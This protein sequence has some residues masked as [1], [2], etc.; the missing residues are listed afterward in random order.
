MESDNGV[1]RIVTNYPE[2][3]VERP[4]IYLVKRSSGYAMIDCG[5]YEREKDFSHL[6]NELNRLGIDTSLIKTLFITH[7]HRDHSL[8]AD[9][10]QHLS[11]AKVFVGKEDYFRISDISLYR[12]RYRRV[13]DYLLFW[14]FKE[15]MVERFYRSFERQFCELRLDLSN[16]VIVDRDMVIDSFEIVSTPGHTSGSICIYDCFNRCLFTGDTLLKKVVLVPVIEFDPEAEEGIS[17]LTAHLGALRRIEGIEYRFIY[18]GHGDRISSD[19]NVIDT[20]FKYLERRSKRVLSLI[21][22]GKNSVYEIARSLYPP[23]TLEDVVTKEAPLVYISDLMMPLEYLLLNKKIK[24]E[25]GI[26]R[27][28]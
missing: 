21:M 17:M 25:D 3:R 18:P 11:G 14:G 28:V 16:T 6:C 23:G 1:I 13:R 5:G 26:I 20:I 15:D 4:N 2:L 9:L 8:L 10:M 19:M 7:T 22:E 27:A 24:V 12:D